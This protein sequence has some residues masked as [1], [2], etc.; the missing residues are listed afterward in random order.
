MGNVK[1]RQ[2]DKGKFRNYLKKAQEYNDSMR[3]SY[4]NGAWNSCV[5]NAVHC[6]ISAIDAL[7]VFY[8]GLRSAGEKHTD[9][10]QLLTR[11]PFPEDEIDKKTTQISM[12][13]SIKYVAEY[14]DR[15]MN[16]T[17][18]QRAVT[19]CDRIFAWVKEKTKE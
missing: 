6:V 8:L 11:L 19:S 16:E 3:A 10:T 13:L 7:T 14:D 17:D 2:M 9:V 18:A 1:T 5:G 12:L 15:L 4:D